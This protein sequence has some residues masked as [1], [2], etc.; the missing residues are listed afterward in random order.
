MIRRVLLGVFFIY[1]A[2]WMLGSYLIEFKLKE[3]LDA[4]KDLSIQYSKIKTSGFPT[5]WE[6]EII[7]PIIKSDDGNG[8]FETKNITLKISMNFKKFTLS[9][10][11]S[12]TMS[13]L[14]SDVSIPNVYDLAFNEPPKLIIKFKN[15]AFQDNNISNNLQD[16]IIT[17]FSMVISNDNIGVMEIQ[18]KISSISKIKDQDFKFEY[19]ISSDSNF[20]IMG[21][22]KLSVYFLTEFSFFSQNNAIIL[23]A[24][25]S[26][27]CEI[28]IDDDATLDLSGSMEFS[29]DKVPDGRLI[30]NLYNYNKLVDLLWPSYFRI[31]NED[32]KSIIEKCNVNDNDGNAYLPIEFSEE[33][34]NIG[35]E[36]WQTLQGE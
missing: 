14:Q 18:N 21:F 31:S 10:Y 12:A 35:E 13:F 23:R 3:S 11:N 20:D 16:I 5:K 32:I 15:L 33:G 1:L 27:A 36:T 8:I 29:A 4:Y 26:K 22:S 24:L 2:I 9:M 6:F 19:D 28:K 7:S 34:L 30:L 25:K 17:P